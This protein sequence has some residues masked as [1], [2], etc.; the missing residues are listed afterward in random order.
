[1]IHVAASTDRQSRKPDPDHGINLA[2]LNRITGKKQQHNRR[3]RE[4]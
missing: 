3:P 2:L 4:E 1:M